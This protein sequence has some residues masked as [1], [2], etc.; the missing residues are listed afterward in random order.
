MNLIGHYACAAMPS[1]EARAGSVLPDLVALYRRKV[2]PLALVRA[3]SEEG[4]APERPRVMEALL[5]GVAF[6]YTV[7]AHFHRA[8]VFR[9]SADAIQAALLGASRAPGLKRFLPAHVLTEL[10]LDHLLLRR[11]PGLAEG[12]YG[13]L[14]DTAGLLETFVARHPLAEAASYRAFL[15]RIVSGRFVDAYTSRAGLFERMNRILPHLGQR[16]LGPAE[17]DAVAAHW[18]R[19]A[20]ETEVRL[21]R[22]VHDMQHL[23]PRP[24]PED[25]G[26][27]GRAAAAGAWGPGTTSVQFA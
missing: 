12:F 26:A 1:P 23:A 22:F 27:D 4:A 5:A 24:L 16:T 11:D 18:R 20:E 17:Q 19:T 6:H 14:A 10:F 21:E 8:P 3:W 7:D 15:E 2:R 9:E 25:T 13:D